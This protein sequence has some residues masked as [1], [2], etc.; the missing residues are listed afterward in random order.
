MEELRN[1]LQQLRSY[2]DDQETSEKLRNVW[3]RFFSYA[4]LVS[5][6]FF[7][8]INCFITYWMFKDYKIM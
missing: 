4:D 1:C 2:I 6:A 8:V 7:T 5:M 3:Q